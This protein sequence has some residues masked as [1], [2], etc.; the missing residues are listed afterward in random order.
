[1]VFI[2]FV[3]VLSNKARIPANVSI[4]I[5]VLIL[6]ISSISSYIGILQVLLI[7]VIFGTA[8]VI[9]QALWRRLSG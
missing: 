4:P 7:L 3:Y 5:T 1:M 2:G 9:I 8:A 6:L